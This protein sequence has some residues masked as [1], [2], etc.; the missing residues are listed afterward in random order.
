M[1]FKPGHE[2]LKRDDSLYDIC[3]VLDWNITSRRRN[4]GSAIFFHLA[5]PGYEPTAGCVALK[6]RDMMR[7]LPHLKKGT[8]LRVL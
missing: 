7:L 4:H 5:R 6:M 8:I 1:P 3:I 2:L